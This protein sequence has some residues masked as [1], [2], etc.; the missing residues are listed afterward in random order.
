MTSWRTP[1][2]HFSTRRRVLEATRARLRHL[3]RVAAELP[4]RALDRIL[5]AW[6]RSYPARREWS[7]RTAALALGLAL[8]LATA[9]C[10]LRLPWLRLPIPL[11]T[12]LFGC[13]DGEDR[14]HSI[15]FGDPRLGTLAFKP[16]FSTTC[17]FNGYR[18][19]HRGDH[20]GFRNPED[21]DHADVVL[22]GDSMT[23][24]HGIQE[25]ETVAHHL[26]ADLGVRVSNLGITSGCPVEYVAYLRN[27]ALRLSP[28]VVVVLAFANDVQ[29]IFS[30]RTLAEV[31]RF[32]RDGEAPELGIDDPAAIMADAPHP[33]QPSLAWLVRWTLTYQTYRYYRPRVEEFI[34]SWRE[35]SAASWLEG[36]AWARERDPPPARIDPAAGA[37]LSGDDD[38]RFHPIGAPEVVAY[39]RRSYRVMAESAR[40]AKVNLVLAYLPKL[41]AE[42]RREDALMA[43]LLSEIARKEGL[44]F[45]DLRA[46][47]SGPDGVAYPEDR[48]P[49][50]GHLS[51]RGAR[52]VSAVVS[53]FLKE[54][55]LL[56]R[57]N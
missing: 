17:Y 24:G 35:A 26:R 10:V 22:L 20:W 1:R 8:S 18:W 4:G 2:D 42:S 53:A 38:S 9:E 11:A 32:V 36:T 50:D 33:S 46:K 13:Y 19:N 55:R 23:Y 43:E 29:D 6:W 37:S 12:R 34:D 3:R 52:R 31:T 54:N 16:H 40:E 28:K 25:N 30:K 51:A 39:A 44:P 5:R 21:W 45:L 7:G 49:V 48:L 27:F 47:L 15:Y 57:E 14:Y 41:D 56:T